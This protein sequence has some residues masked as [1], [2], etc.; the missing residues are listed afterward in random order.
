MRWQGDYPLIQK[1]TSFEDVKKALNKTVSGMLDGKKLNPTLKLD[2]ELTS[3]DI[4]GNLISDIERLQPFGSENPNP[5]FAMYNLTLNQKKLM[6]SNKNHLKLVV[7]DS[8][9]NT[10]DC[11]WWSKGDISLNSGDILDIAFCPQLNTFNGNTTIQFILQDVHSDKLI[12]EEEQN[13]QPFKIYD[14][15]KKIGIYTSVEDYV[16]TSNL[17]IGIFAEDKDIINSLKPYKA[18]SERIFNRYSDNNF[19]AIM[20]FDYPATQDIFENIIEKYSPKFIHFMNYETTGFDEKNYLK[21]LQGMLKFASNTKQGQFEIKRA[22]TFL[23]LTDEIVQETLSIFEKSKII[24]I[25][26]QDKDVYS[27]E[28]LGG[29]VSKVLHAE[30]Y[31]MLLS[32]IKMIKDYKDSFA[33]ADLDNFINFSAGY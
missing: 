15:R 13:E 25:K 4:N 17:K 27:I 2:L 22:S 30:E 29:E 5:I 19:D 9:N 28:F 33:D 1:K 7:E 8:Q 3:N 6:G 18:I 32:D 16:K 23:G 10:Y 31:S 20:F 24:N 26:S 21:T 14:H 11:I 12:D